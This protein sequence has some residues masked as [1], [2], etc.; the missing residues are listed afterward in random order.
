[1][2]DPNN[3]EDPLEF[4]P[5]RFLDSSRSSQKDAI[6]EEV[7]RYIAFGSGRRGCPGANLAYVSV[8]TAIGVM[9]QCFDWKIKGDKINMNEAAG[10]ITITMANPLTCSL[11]PRTQISLSSK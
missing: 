1:M 7:L 9:V 6:K 2:R 10:K 3:W 8:E 5:E 11:V 4:K